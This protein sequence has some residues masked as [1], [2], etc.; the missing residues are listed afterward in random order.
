[1]AGAKNL[2]LPVAFFIG[3]VLEATMFGKILLQLGFGA[4]LTTIPSRHIP[5]SFSTR[6]RFPCKPATG[7]LAVLGVVVSDVWAGRST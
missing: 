1:M 3:T 2:P 4:V 7:S 5:G 6:T